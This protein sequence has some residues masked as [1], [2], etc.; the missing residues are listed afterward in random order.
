MSV[1]DAAERIGERPGL[2]ILT[3][4]IVLGLYLIPIVLLVAAVG[5]LGLIGLA[6][7]RLAIRTS[8]SVVP[9]PHHRV[10]GQGARLT[11]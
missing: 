4:K 11:P 1:H 5:G 8:G 10:V 6:A 9:E 7:G 3:L 2:M